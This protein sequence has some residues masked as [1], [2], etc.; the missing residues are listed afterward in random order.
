MQLEL[1]AAANLRSICVVEGSAALLEIVI[2]AGKEAGSCGELGSCF[3]FA[4]E[5]MKKLPAQVVGTSA[6]ST[7]GESA[8][9]HGKSFCGFTVLLEQRRET[10]EG[11]GQPG[12]ASDGIAV[13]GL[14][15]RPVA[16]Q[17]SDPAKLIVG[18]GKV[19][20]EVDFRDQLGARG[21][22]LVLPV[23]R[24]REK[25]VCQG[26]RGLRGDGLLEFGLGAGEILLAKRGFAGEEM[27][28]RRVITG[29][30]HLLKGPVGKGGSVGSCGGAAKDVEVGQIGAL[31]PPKRF[32]GL[33]STRVV[34]GEEA[35]EAEQEAGLGASRGL[36]ENASELRD[37]GGVVGC[38]EIRKAEVKGNP[39]HVG[40][41]A[42]SLLKGGEGF[43]PVFFRA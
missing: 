20:F 3:R 38:V 32:K 30:R 29:N 35:A 6:S 23:K 26:Q 39:G 41:E 37:G 36:S 1:C 13:G 18:E 19:G 31:G 4:V 16:K 34:R 10:E 21:L 40:V 43:G 7:H 25:E 24:F 28:L 9:E 2:E 42:S 11:G 22:L 27:E 15:R 8:I 12:I 14:C 33:S 17:R 5:L